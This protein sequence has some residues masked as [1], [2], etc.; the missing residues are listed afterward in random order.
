[1][2]YLDRTNTRGYDGALQAAVQQFQID[3]G[4]NADGVA[5]G[6]TMAQINV[7]VDERLKSVIVALERERWFNTDRG[8]RHILVNI[9]DFSAK[10]ID[11]GKV[12]F[13][14]RSVVGARTDGSPTPEFSDV[15]EHMVIN[16][17]GMSRAQS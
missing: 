9:P 7:S 13:Q 1:M 8:K 2:D 15:M 10:I 3:H 14:T 4:L 6:T 12:T 5:G 11:D 16:Q 17:A